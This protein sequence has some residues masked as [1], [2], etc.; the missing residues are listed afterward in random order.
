MPGEAKNPFTRAILK[1]VSDPALREFV[2]YWDALEFL[3]IRVFRAKAASPEDEA[4][5]DRI[6]SWLTSNYWRWQEA[7]VPY[8]EQALVAGQ[9]AGKDPFLFLLSNPSSD[10]F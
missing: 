6:R 3:V 8:W 5:Y 2:V 9:P 1:Q 7:L 4:E 10:W